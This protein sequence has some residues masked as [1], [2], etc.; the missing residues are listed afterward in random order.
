MENKSLSPLVIEEICLIIENEHKVQLA[1]YGSPLILDAFKAKKIIADRYS[2]T[3]PDISPLIGKSVVLEVKTSKKKLYIHTYKRTPKASKEMRNNS[4]NV[5]KITNTYNGKI[6]P[7]KAKFVLFV[8]KEEWE[9]TIFVFKTG[10]LTEEI[11]GYNGLPEE[12]VKDKESLIL[13]LDSWFESTGIKY[14]VDKLDNNLIKGLVGNGQSTE[15][16]KY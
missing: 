6:V 12:A 4:C 13:F 8:F 15:K 3:R 16:K 14:K 10:V 5:S 11:Q 1:K 7:E 9:K 2:Y